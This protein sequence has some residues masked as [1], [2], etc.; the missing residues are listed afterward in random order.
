MRSL[1]PSRSTSGRKS[2]RAN[3]ISSGRRSILSRMCSPTSSSTPRV[4]S[5]TSPTGMPECPWSPR[6]RTSTA[7]RGN[8]ARPHRNSASTPTRSCR[9]SVPATIPDLNG[10]LQIEQKLSRSVRGRRG[11]RADQER[12]VSW[13]IPPPT[14]RSRTSCRDRSTRCITPTTHGRTGATSS[15]RHPT[16]TC[17]WRPGTATTRTP[18]RGLGYVKV[19]FADGRHYDLLAGTAGGRW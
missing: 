11:R 14:S 13:A 9:N 18:R 10:T 4:A 12:A 5:S 16:A 1:Q 19:T 17:C 7:R 8:R 2:L 15:P 3:R 6:P